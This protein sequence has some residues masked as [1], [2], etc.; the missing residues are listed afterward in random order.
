M[1]SQLNILIAKVLE[2]C[3][4]YAMGAW[5][6]VPETQHSNFWFYGPII[7]GLCVAKPA[8]NCFSMLCNLLYKWRASKLMFNDMMNT[9]VKAP[10]N[11]YFDVTPSGRILNRFSKDLSVI[12]NHLVWQINHMNHVVW[13]LLQVFCIAIYIVPQ[14]TLVMVVVLILSYQI[15]SRTA[16]CMK[17]MA[18][19]SSTIRSPLLSYL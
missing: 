10:V 2:L 7:I 3:S 6:Y 5:A 9:V 17:E 16:T 15:V 8:T 19:I 4:D 1:L 13:G 18:R 12:E 14:I 11:L